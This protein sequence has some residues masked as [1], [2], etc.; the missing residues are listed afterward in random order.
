MIEDAVQALDDLDMIEIENKHQFDDLI[1]E[2]RTLPDDLH[3]PCADDGEEHPMISLL[4]EKGGLLM[5]LWPFIQLMSDNRLAQPGSP[6]ADSMR[7]GH[8]DMIP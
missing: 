8:E 1:A 2:L 7:G 5:S 4:M 6:D 3:P